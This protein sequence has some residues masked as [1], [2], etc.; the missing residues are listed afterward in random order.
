[1]TTFEVESYY[2]YGRRHQTEQHWGNKKSCLL[3]EERLLVIH[4]L[5]SLLVIHVREQGPGEVVVV[6]AADVGAVEL[7]GDGDT[8][9]ETYLQPDTD[10]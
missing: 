3:S 1:M 7:L 8:V 6:P 2:A 4:E 5:Q 9:V 10:S